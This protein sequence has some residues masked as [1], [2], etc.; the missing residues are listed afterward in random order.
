[1]VAVATEIRMIMPSERDLRLRRGAE[2]EAVPEIP[3]CPS[4]GLNIA[5][6]ASVGPSCDLVVFAEEL[7]KLSSLW[8]YR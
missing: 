1:V 8:P 3:T 6:E 2:I 7:A 5:V 4:K